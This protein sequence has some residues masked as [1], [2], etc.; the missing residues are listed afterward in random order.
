V[1]TTDVWTFETVAASFVRKAAGYTGY[2]YRNYGVE[3]EDVISEINVWLF[4]DGRPKV[5]KWLGNEPQQTTRIYRSMLDV[6]LKYAESEKANR[7]GYKPDDVWW[8]TKTSVEGLMP[9]ALDPTYTQANGHVGE[10]LTMVVD[11][12]RVM[13]PED[14]DYFTYCDDTDPDWSERLTDL[15]NRLGGQRPY[16]G[17]RKVLSN[18]TAQAITETGYDR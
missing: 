3:P 1:S 7:V 4:G 8:Y 12:R 16:V 17:R 10:T 14:H 11:I 5:E 6:A 2:R 18:A 15:V 9:L 13:T